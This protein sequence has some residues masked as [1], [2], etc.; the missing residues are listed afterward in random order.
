L[1]IFSCQAERARK[2]AEAEL[3]ET[4]QRVGELTAMVTSLA[5]DR[6]RFDCDLTSAR[7]DVEDALRQRTEATDRAA[8]LQASRI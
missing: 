2:N 3:S 5:A 4:T 1:H 7:A 8:K 6:R